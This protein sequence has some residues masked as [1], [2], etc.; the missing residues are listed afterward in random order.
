MPINSRPL[1]CIKGGK[2]KDEKYKPCTIINFVVNLSD[3]N[4]AD[5][6]T[7]RSIT[8]LLCM[9]LSVQEGWQ[10]QRQSWKAASCRWCPGTCL[11]D[12]Q[13]AS[14][15]KFALLLLETQ[16]HLYFLYEL[17]DKF[18]VLLGQ[19]HTGL[20]VTFTSILWS[21]RA[22]MTSPSWN[23]Q[24]QLTVCPLRGEIENRVCP[25]VQPACIYLPFTLAQHL[26]LLYVAGVGADYLTK[27]HN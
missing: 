25:P 15:M 21:Y 22:G 3:Q 14:C 16:Q 5:W 9:E 27:Q 20:E 7:C 18:S 4:T 8:L 1:C 24:T 12:K 10:Q 19:C 2:K 17:S 11:G 26:S 13:K 6:T 23:D